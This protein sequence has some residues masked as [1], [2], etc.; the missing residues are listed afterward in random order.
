LEA[1]ATARIELPQQLPQEGLVMP[2][3][4]KVTVTPQQQRLVQGVFEAPVA[5]FDI[6][7]LIAVT[8]LPLDALHSIVIQQSLVTAGELLRTLEG[9]HGGGQTVGAMLLVHPAQLPQG[10]L[11]SLAESFQTFADSARIRASVPIECAVPFRLNKRFDSA[12]KRGPV[13]MQS[14]P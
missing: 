13:P 8:G 7:I 6:A 10:I 3:A 11:Q 14:A 5:L 12:R 4:L 1:G 9:M 2:S